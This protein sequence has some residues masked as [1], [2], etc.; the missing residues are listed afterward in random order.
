MKRYLLV[1]GLPLLLWSNQFDATLENEI[2]WL[3]E[4]SFVVSASRVK[5]NIKKTS[6]SISIIDE[7][8]IS[9]MG[10]NNQQTY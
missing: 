8:M 2:Q 1:L 10:L 9:K 5:E 7:D 3:E 4:E 6:A